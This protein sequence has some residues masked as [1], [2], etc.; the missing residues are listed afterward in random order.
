MIVLDIFKLDQG[1]F[2]RP[3]YLFICDNLKES[4]ANEIQKFPIN[5]VVFV[6]R[7]L[8]RLELEKQ[9]DSN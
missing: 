4:E 7:Q 2:R 8:L 5:N 9:N 3:I 1:W 6:T